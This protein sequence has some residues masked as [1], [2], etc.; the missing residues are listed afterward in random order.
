MWSRL[1]PPLLKNDPWGQL[2]IW[3]NYPEAI[4]PY[5]KMT[6][7]SIFSHFIG[8][9]TLMVLLMM[10][11]LALILKLLYIR[12]DFYYVEHLIFSFHYHAF[13]FLITTLLIFVGKYLSDWIAIP[14]VGIFVYQYIA[15]KRVYTQSYFK[16]FLKFLVLNFLY[17]FLAIIFF[18]LTVLISFVLF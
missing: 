8:K 6:N 1:S 9:L 3:K 11:F 16:T 17:M 5:G 15:M 18:S 12:R 13:V 2:T 14:I 10:P 4:T 7:G